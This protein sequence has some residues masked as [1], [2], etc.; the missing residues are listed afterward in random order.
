MNG[1]DSAGCSKKLTRELR[2]ERG[3]KASGYW[4]KE[5]SE[6]RE[7]QQQNAWCSEHCEQYMKILLFIRLQSSRKVLQDKII[8]QGRM[9]SFKPVEGGKDFFILET[10]K[11]RNP[12]WPK[13][14]H[15]LDYVVGGGCTL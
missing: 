15:D 13:N 1:V 4:G 5:Y 10:G 7:P 8:I 12:D 14:K 9:W 6:Q 2:S 3:I 11:E